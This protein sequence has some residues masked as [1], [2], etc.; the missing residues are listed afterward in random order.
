MKGGGVVIKR[1]KASPMRG[2]VTKRGRTQKA[3]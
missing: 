2:A 1:G 3:L